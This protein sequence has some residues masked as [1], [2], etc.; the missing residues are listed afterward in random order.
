MEMPQST[1]VYHFH[2]L[3]LLRY[4]M[5]Q[6]FLDRCQVRYHILWGNFSNSLLCNLVDDSFE[7]L[8]SILTLWSIVP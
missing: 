6:Q 7:E 5:P 3:W 2:H 4:P 1:I 8:K